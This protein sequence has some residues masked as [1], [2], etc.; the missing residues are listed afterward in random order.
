MSVKE[1]KHIAKNYAQALS[2]LF[3][4]DLSK[5]ESVLEILTSLNEGLSKVENA[6][7]VFNN[8]AISKI[9]KKDL[10][11][12]IL[13]GKL[14]DSKISQELIS[15]LLLIIDKHRFNVLPEI[16]IELSFLIDRLKGIVLAEIYSAADLNAQTIEKLKTTLEK[17]I[18]SAGEKVRIEKKIEPELIGGLK[19]KVKDLVYDGSIRGKLENLKRKLT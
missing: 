13:S 5:L 19:L 12:K 10:L 14:D 18:L 9:E 8:P 11:K 2:E 6:V 17:N 16:Q 3:T 4:N 7:E 1:D 15:F